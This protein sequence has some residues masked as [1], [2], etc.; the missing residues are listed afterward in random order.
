M[1]KQIVNV[2][3]R[4]Y[5]AVTGAL[6]SSEVKPNK[7]AA[8]RP[9]KTTEGEPVQITV[10]KTQAS[11]PTSAKTV[12]NHAKRRQPQSTQTLMRTAVKKPAPAP[13]R[14]TQIQTEVT[15]VAPT[16]I[17]VHHSATHI[18]PLR[19]GKAKQIQKNRHVSRFDSP[20]PHAVPVTFTHVPVQHNPIESTIPKPTPKPA[21][22]LVSKPADM[23][24]QAIANATH[25]VDLTAQKNHFRKKT[26][27]HLTSMATGALALL[28]LAG[29]AAYQNTPGLQI[30]VAGL[31]A[32]VATATPDFAASGFAYNGVKASQS[33]L[34]V[35]LKHGTSNFQLTEQP[36]NWS[37]EDM[38]SQ[39]SSIEA[40]GAP[41]YST[42]TAG[43]HTVYR[44][45]DNQ[46]TW[47][48]NGTW[49]NLSGN[50]TLS[51]DQVKSLV[52]NT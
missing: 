26:R 7:K 51:D 15:H 14:P 27:R 13:K 36:T 16:T 50:G 32:G 43:E 39:I 1:N 52:Q 11:S 35:G 29:F 18:D 20:V 37:S 49:Y 22:A 6:L 46:A 19:L 10:K 3:G 44:F 24:E 38:I 41:N 17:G 30:K 9:V 4:Q 31:R 8:S 12:A 23:F 42:L 33:K 48:K 25:F 2:N 21:P 34:V 28:L 5:D 40:S 47:V 45:G